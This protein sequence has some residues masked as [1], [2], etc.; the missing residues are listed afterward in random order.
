MRLIEAGFAVFGPTRGGCPDRIEQ[1]VLP[2]GRGGG[3]RPDGARPRRSTTRPRPIGVRAAARGGGPGRRR[4]GG[5]AGRRQGRDGLRVRCRGGTGD[6]RSSRRLRPRSRSADGDWV[7]VEERLVG[8]EASLIAVCDGRTRD[9]P[10]DGPRSQAAARWRPRART[11]AGWAPTAR[12]RTCRTTAPTGPA[13]RLPPADPGRAGPPRHPVPWRPLRRPDA[14]R[15]R[16]GP[17]RV[18]RALRRPRDAGDPAAARRR[19]SVRSCWPPRAATSA[20]ALGAS[21]R[22]PRGRLP[23]LPGATVAI[24]LAAAGY[25]DAPRRGD[26]I[27][28]LDDAAATR[29]ARLPRRD[30]RGRRRDGPDGA[31]AG[32]SPSSV[33]GPTSRRR[34]AAADGRRG[35][36]PMRRASSAGTTSAGDGSSRRRPSRRAG[37]IVGPMIPRYTLPEMGAIWSDAARFEAM[38]RVE[39]AVARAQ[40]ARGQIP[41]DALAAL[42]IALARRRR[43]DRRDRAHDRPRR[44]RL[45]Q[46]GRRVGRPRRALPPPR[47]DQQRRRRHRARAPAARG[48]RAPARSTA[49]GCWPCSSRGLAPRP[50][51]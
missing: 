51:P 31:A 20:P 4:Q 3:R 19:R 46:P 34:P 13:R 28:G 12:S 43:A 2:R 42:E 33:A 50:R 41:P 21:R 26:P 29:R 27:D 11:R 49:T 45:R 47:A 30:G 18:Q 5:R 38:L 44:H 37:R 10:A 22:C 6:R 25:P 16:P 8:R 36:D 17:A 9:R 7:V 24:V 15:R 14:H 1:G 35:P 40:S 23:T 48:R 32:S 39:L